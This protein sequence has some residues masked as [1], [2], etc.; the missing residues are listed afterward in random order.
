ME[1]VSRPLSPQEH[2][3]MAHAAAGR[4]PEE[5]GVLMF[6]Q[7]STV[8]NHR[9]RALAALG[10]RGSLPRGVAKWMGL[11]DRV[12]EDRLEWYLS[13]H[14]HRWAL[15]WRGIPNSGPGEEEENDPGPVLSSAGSVPPSPGPAE[16]FVPL[17]LAGAWLTS[18][19]R[20]HWR[21]RA[22]LTKLWRDSTA[23]LA[24][25]ANVPRYRTRVRVTA[26]VVCAGQRRRDIGNWYPTVK[27]C[28]DGLVDARVIPDDSDRWVMGP[29]LRPGMGAMGS[30]PGILFRIEPARIINRDTDGSK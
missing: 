9:N 11:T 2:R 16:L 27:A 10:C 4:S 26:V 29:D 17:S 7:T 15:V 25:E 14:Q 3:V 23:V 6:L 28:V 5:T 8:R 30:P 18:N 22:A 20:E 19:G 12:V 13:N 21:T 1:A 24:R